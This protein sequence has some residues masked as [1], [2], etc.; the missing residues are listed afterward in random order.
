MENRAHLPLWFKGRV[1]EVEK[2]GHK[3]GAKQAWEVIE[4]HFG[5]CKA[6][7]AMRT[8]GEAL[9]VTLSVPCTTDEKK[10]PWGGIEGFRAR[11]QLGLDIHVSESEGLSCYV[12]DFFPEQS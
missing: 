5:H 3:A 7:T 8:E 9:R 12:L 4:R 11:F 10:T 6:D 2:L 1:A